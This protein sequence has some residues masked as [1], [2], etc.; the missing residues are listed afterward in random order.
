[1]AAQNILIGKTIN[2]SNLKSLLATGSLPEN[3]GPI[4]VR[5]EGNQQALLDRSRPIAANWAKMMDYLET[6]NRPV[7]V[8]TDASTG[9]INKLYVPEAARVWQIDDDGSATV[10]VSFHTSSALYHLNRQHPQ[11]QTMLDALRVALEKDANILV[12]ATSP[13]F[14]IIDVRELPPSYGKEEPPTGPPSLAASPED[15]TPAKPISPDRAMELFQLMVDENCTPCLST[16][17]CIPFKYPPDGCWIRAHLMCYLMVDKGETPEKIWSQGKLQAH[18]ANVPN[19][20]VS[21]AWHVAPTLLVEQKGAGPIKMVFDPS[22]CAA[23]VP[24]E[25][26]I[27]LQTDPNATLRPS[28]WEWYNRFGGSA[29][30]Q[31]ANND[32]E[33]YRIYLDQMCSEYGPSPYQ[34]LVA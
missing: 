8:E 34:C 11:F 32:M 12:T 30:Q 9:I 28:P 7:Y 10:Q 6:S 24:V 21:W 20:L 33:R 25:E 27:R 16:D 22:L 18:S 31:V 4:T 1:M 17:S 3:A 2:R 23:P 13:E 26:W 29:T 15:P 14:E 19:C 5:F